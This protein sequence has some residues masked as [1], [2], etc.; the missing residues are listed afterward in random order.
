MGEGR[1]EVDIGLDTL[2]PARKR[3]GVPKP[4]RIPRCHVI[5]WDSDDHTYDYVERLLAGKAVLRKYS[6]VVDKVA[7]AS[8]YEAYFELKRVY[9]RKAAWNKEWIREF[10]SF[11][12]GK[13]DDQVDSLV[14]ALN[15]QIKASGGIGIS[16]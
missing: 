1:H 3:S 14:V 11:P 9:L 15:E 8:N 16:G 12:N 13:H 10:N 6:P 7:R 4:Q 5:L 2:V